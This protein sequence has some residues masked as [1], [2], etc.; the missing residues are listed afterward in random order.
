MIGQIFTGELEPHKNASSAEFW[1]CVQ[2]S[3]KLT[4]LKLSALKHTKTFKLTFFKAQESC[5]HSEGKIFQHS[6]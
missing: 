5:E 4:W 3:A 2:R 6:L 1:D